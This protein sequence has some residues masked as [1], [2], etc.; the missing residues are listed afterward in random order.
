MPLLLAVLIASL[1]CVF[2]T[3]VTA[4]D[5]VT[6]GASIAQKADEQLRGY[7]DSQVGLTMELTGPSGQTATRALRVQSLET[8]G[9]EYT[10]M[11]FDTPRDVA[12]TSLLS[13]NYRSREDQQWLYLPAIRRVKQIGARD[14]SGPFMGSEFAYEDIV[15]P[16]FEKFSY[17]LEGEE[18]C[19]GKPCWIVERT[20]K[21]P[22]SGY[23]R[24]R[25]WI[26]QERYLIHRIE[27][28]DRRDSLLKTYT[29][30]HFT[31][32]EAAHWRPGQM[33][34]VNHQNQRQT[35]LI[36]SDFRFSTGL[37]DR[38]FSQN[39]LMRAR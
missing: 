21:D 8:D 31:R 7:G 38:D 15:T 9:G 5:A 34:M 28:F 10:L 3:I 23:T 4:E 36:W 1:F 14:K 19:A 22:Y 24:Q 12:G 17:R 30:S 2:S 26:D 6:R 20:P 32:H 27:Y 33:Q 13:H 11:I 25:V 39:A 35:L 29:A 18:A 16:F 37:N